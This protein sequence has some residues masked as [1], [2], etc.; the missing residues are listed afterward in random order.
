MF[1]VQ[2]F[3][4]GSSLQAQR[5]GIQS[6]PEGRFTKLATPMRRENALKAYPGVGFSSGCN[7]RIHLFK[8]KISL[9]QLTK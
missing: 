8:I 3:V 6:I 7:M 5:E 2:L 1:L 4:S 9:L